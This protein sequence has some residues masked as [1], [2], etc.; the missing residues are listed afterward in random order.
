[1][2]QKLSTIQ[3]WLVNIF[4]EHN[5]PKSGSSVSHIPSKLSLN[6][7]NGK[8]ALKEN[9]RDAVIKGHPQLNMQSIMFDTT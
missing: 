7:L 9:F 8:I 4:R 1:L 2:K 3:G 5:M 6:H